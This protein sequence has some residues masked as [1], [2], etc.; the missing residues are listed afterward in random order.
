MKILA[1]LKYVFTVLGAALLIGAVTSYNNVSGFLKDA[2]SVQGTVVKMV[3][4]SGGDSTT[5]KP[6]VAFVVSE[7]HAVQIT[8]NVGSNPPAYSVGD[9]IE[10]L[11]PPETPQDAR[12][13]SFF[14][15]WWATVFMVSMGAPLF[16]I[17]VVIFSLG[18]M[19]NRKRNYLQQNGEAISA[20]F[21]AVAL[22]RK[23]SVNGRNPFVVVCHWLNPET[24]EVHVFESESIWFDPS[25][26]IGGEELMVFIKK[27]NPKKYHVDI[28]FLPKMAR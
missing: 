21:Q 17:G 10:V 12:I 18:R 2:V 6:I 13:N 3:R 22:N 15:L 24:S 4:S 16:I 14:D 19:G 23:I 5:Y 27:G 28:S 25:S 7:G 20:R 26:Y 9:S 8:S 1:V 11:Y